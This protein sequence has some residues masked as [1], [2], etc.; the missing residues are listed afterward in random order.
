MKKILALFLLAGIFGLI[1]PSVV[2]GIE[3]ENPLQY[4][5]FDALVEGI[6][7][8]LIMLATPL[9]TLMIVIAAFYFVTSAGNPQ[10]I[11][12]AKKIIYIP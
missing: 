8:F 7:R 2:K 10:Q 6:I 3:I 12:T 9:A 1:L 11:E 4:E 5:S